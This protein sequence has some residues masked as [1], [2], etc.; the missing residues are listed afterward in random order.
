[1]TAENING[2][3]TVRDEDGGRWWP[4]EEAANQIATA[5]DPSVEALQICTD[6]PMRGKWH[7]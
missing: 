5:N 2:T 1:M 4:N 6:E 7:Q 3:W